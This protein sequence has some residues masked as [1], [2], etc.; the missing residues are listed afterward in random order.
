[1]GPPAPAI[2]QPAESSGCKCQASGPREDDSQQDDLFGREALPLLLRTWGRGGQGVQP[3]KVSFGREERDSAPSAMVEKV[4]PRKEQGMAC[5][6]LDACGG[7]TFSGHPRPRRG[8][9]GHGGRQHGHPSIVNKD[10]RWRYPASSYCQGP[11]GPWKRGQER[12]L[13]G[14]VLVPMLCLQRRC[15]GFKVTRQVAREPSR[16]LGKALGGDRARTSVLEKNGAGM[17]GPGPQDGPR[18]RWCNRRGGRLTSV[19][20]YQEESRG[21]DGEVPWGWA[22]GRPER[23]EGQGLQCGELLPPTPAKA[24]LVWGSLSRLLSHQP[25]DPTSSWW[26]RPLLCMPPPHLLQFCP[27]HLIPVTG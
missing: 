23:V 13:R 2:C 5:R 4:R 11:V 8:T 17:G 6:R 22:L 21:E 26:S 18:R 24:L 10:C 1:M 19:P 3:K 9:S 27:R 25:C 16:E 14:L 12:G 20:G 15:G 7:P